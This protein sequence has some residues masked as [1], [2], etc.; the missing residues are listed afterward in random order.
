MAQPNHDALRQFIPL[1]FQG[2]PALSRTEAVENG[3]DYKLPFEK[4]RPS[5]QDSDTDQQPAEQEADPKGADERG[6]Q[7]GRA[8]PEQGPAQH[9]TAKHKTTAFR[10]KSMRRKA[11][12]MPV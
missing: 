1:P 6:D 12:L 11:V 4:L 8:G 7:K 5:G 10:R 2:Q 3:A 9:A